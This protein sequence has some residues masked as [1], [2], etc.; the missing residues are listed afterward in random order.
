[1]SHRNDY[2]T[3]TAI[4]REQCQRAGFDVVHALQADWYNNVVDDPHRLPVFERANTLAIIIGNTRALWPRFLDWLRSHPKWLNDAN[5]L[6]RYVMANVTAALQPLTV[7]YIIR[8][9]HLPDPHHIAFQRL[10][11]I[12]GLA[13]LSPS[14][15]SVHP[16]FGPWIAL[17]AV[18][19]VDCDGPAARPVDMA[20]PCGTC[21]NQCMPLFNHALKAVGAFLPGHEAVGEHWQTWLSIRD[22]CP[23]GKEHRYSEEQIRY[24]YIKDISLLRELV[25]A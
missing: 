18:V 19:V 11:H 3:I 7:K 12:A 1:M 5:P 16:N 22:A 6:D 8:W 2:E 25:D 14:Y 9:A 17:R 13:Y 23:V 24:H 20:N 4:V 10:A 15:L 21:E